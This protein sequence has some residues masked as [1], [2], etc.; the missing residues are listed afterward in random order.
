M[1]SSPWNRANLMCSK[2]IQL[3][4]AGFHKYNM[5][6][7]YVIWIHFMVL[8]CLP[9]FKD[10]GNIIAYCWAHT[11]YVL[12]NNEHIT[13]KFNWFVL[14]NEHKVFIVRVLPSGFWNPP[15]ILVC[16]AK[17]DWNIYEVTS[18]RSCS[19]EPGS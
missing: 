3:I 4:H 17:G 13:L 19:S 1:K 8:T 16:P 18:F 14:D 7:T 15:M 9:L 6:R 2:H 5:K 10:I 11:N 12:G